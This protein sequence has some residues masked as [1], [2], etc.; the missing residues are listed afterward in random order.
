M[1]SS[2]EQELAHQVAILTPENTSGL[3]SEQ[4]SRFLSFISTLHLELLDNSKETHLNE[5]RFFIDEVIK[6]NYSDMLNLVI[7]EAI[8]RGD[9]QA[10]QRIKDNGQFDLNSFNIAILERYINNTL[11]YYTEHWTKVFEEKFFNVETI[12]SLINCLAR[13]L[14]IGRNLLMTESPNSF[15]PF[16][17]LNDQIKMAL[18]LEVLQSKD[19]L[20]EKLI[21][22]LKHRV[23]MTI[24]ETAPPSSSPSFFFQIKDPSLAQN[25]KDHTNSTSWIKKDGYYHCL[26]GDLKDS[27]II[28]YRHD[29]LKNANRYF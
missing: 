28:Y 20:P 26:E 19:Y 7:A 27:R 11:H 6:H 3:S 29:N 9:I 23:N 2:Q 13:E 10:L 21:H 8:F 24:K 15:M 14:E 5:K 16:K 22:D 12:S 25:K 17:F 18:F 4:V 1:S